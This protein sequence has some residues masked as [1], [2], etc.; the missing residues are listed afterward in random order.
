MIII[1]N[2]KKKVSACCF[3]MFQGDFWDKSSS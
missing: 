1:D 2:N 3:G